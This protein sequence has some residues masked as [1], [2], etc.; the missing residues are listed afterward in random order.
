[1]VKA[2]SITAAHRDIM[3]KDFKKEYSLCQDLFQ[4]YP[5]DSAAAE[6]QRQ[7]KE[8][9][10]SI[11]SFMDI[12]PKNKK[13]EVDENQLEGSFL[14]VQYRKQKEQMMNAMM[15]NT[16]PVKSKEVKRQRMG[17]S[18]STRA[19]QSI[20]FKEINKTLIDF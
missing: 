17:T 12:R 18:Q 19:M 5:R 20:N 8:E 2:H 7:K 6:A 11:L 9:K 13:A 16:D 15:L 4:I 10:E 14:N 1:M 3:Y